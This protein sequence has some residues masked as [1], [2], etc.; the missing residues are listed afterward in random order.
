[1]AANGLEVLDAIERAPY[2]VVLM[3]VQM[4]EMD[5]LEATRRLRA[6]A[7]DGRGPYVVA[8]TANAMREDRDLCLAAGMDDYLSKPVRPELLFAALERC[9]ALLGRS[10]ADLAA[11]HATSV[12]G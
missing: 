11:L 1:M 8:L 7:A 5:G 9:G 3:D 12:A 10:A 4:P 6:S 2:D